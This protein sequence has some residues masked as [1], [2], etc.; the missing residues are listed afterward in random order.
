MESKETSYKTNNEQVL[1]HNDE[2]FKY[3]FKKTE[4]IVCAVFYT[5]RMNRDI[6][7][8]DKVILDIEDTAHQLMDISYKAL[9]ATGGSRQM[10]LED[11]SYA[12]VVLES[13][14]NIVQA[15][16]LLERDLLEVFKHEIDSVQRALKQYTEKTETNPLTEST[17]S[18]EIRVPKRLPKLMHE[19]TQSTVQR[20]P[21]PSD[22][23]SRRERVIAVLRDKGEAT[24]KDISESVTDCSEKTIQ[25]ELIGLIK[26]GIIVRE[27][28]RRW[29]KYKVV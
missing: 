11:V 25:R 13:K 14:L 4:K 15:A 18:G 28:E 29:S 9:R 1:L 2:Y 21:T 7:H 22:V 20:V 23:P 3:I 26:D 10:R 24:I 27:G 17:Y 6:S 16:Q 5:V 19:R 8:G 12:L